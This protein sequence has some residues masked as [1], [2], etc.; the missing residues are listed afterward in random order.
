[1]GP[2]GHVSVDV[3]PEVVMMMSW[4]QSYQLITFISSCGASQSVTEKQ[5]VSKQGDKRSNLFTI[6]YY[7]LYVG[8]D[9]TGHVA[10]D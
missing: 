7:E 6:D 5:T 1:M 9:R 10:C 8:V 2:H 3:D 4:L